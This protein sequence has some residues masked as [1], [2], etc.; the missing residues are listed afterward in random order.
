MRK[1]EMKFCTSLQKWLKY[2][3]KHT[4]FIEAKIS[5]DD[6]PFN[7]NSGFKPHQLPTL[8]SIKHNCMAYKIS[9]MDRMQK[10]FDIIFAR[11]DKAYVAIMWIRKGNKVFYLI[12]PD[13]VQGEIDSGLK[14]MTEARAEKL[15]VIRGILK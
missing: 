8:S 10:P 11:M 15:A 2:N 12:D 5:I 7:F 1:H 3:M 4:C 13:T 6:K 9:D 14:S